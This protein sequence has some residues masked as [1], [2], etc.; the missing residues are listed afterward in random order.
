MFLSISYHADV[1][2]L[3]GQTQD[4]VVKRTLNTF[5]IQYID[6]RQELY[7]NQEIKVYLPPK[8]T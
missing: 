8:H 3:K 5:Y 1:S 7:I 6:L 2:M 4:V